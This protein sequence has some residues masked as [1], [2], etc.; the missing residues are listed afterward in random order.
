MLRY[1]LRRNTVAV[2]QS[3]DRVIITLRDGT[4]VKVPDDFAKCIGFVEVGWG[5]E[6]V[7][8]FAVDLRDHGELIK[9][10]SA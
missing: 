6:K 1:R 4:I 3:N 9:A 7:Q 2:F 10:Q 5:C 8:M